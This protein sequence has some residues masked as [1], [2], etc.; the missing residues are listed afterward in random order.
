MKTKLSTM[1]Q[2]FTKALPLVLI[3]MLLAGTVGVMAATGT[4]DSPAAPG[5][6]NS[7][8]LE[9]IYQRLDAGTAASQSTFTEPSVAPGTGTM[10]DLNDIY[11]AIPAEGSDLTGVNGSL[12][13][14]IV[15]GIYRSKTATANDS[16]LK[17]DNIYRGIPIFGVTGTLNPSGIPKT[18]QTVDH[19]FQDDGSMEMGVAWPNPRFTDNGDGTVTDHLTNLIWLKDAW[20]KD[21]PGIIGYSPPFSWSPAITWASKV[22]DGYCG[23]TDGSNAFDWRLPNVRELQSLVDYSR[24]NP[25]LPA[26]HPFINVHPGPGVYWSSTTNGNLSTWAWAVSFDEGFVTTA[27]KYNAFFSTARLVWAV[28]GGN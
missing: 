28:R 9:D 17:A 19:G 11:N 16:N 8:T 18:G 5:S 20:C 3:A 10:H 25:A 7:Y 27:E 12:T 2:H 23:L 14:N 21:V 15:D 26:G 4:I 6:T 13:V 1:W 22:E 24:V